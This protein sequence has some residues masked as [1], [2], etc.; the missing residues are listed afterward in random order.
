MSG[1]WRC[2]PAGHATTPTPATEPGSA[3]G[4]TTDHDRLGL[5]GVT[6]GPLRVVSDRRILLDVH[7][8]DGDVDRGDIQAEQILHRA[9]HLLPDLLGYRVDL[10]AELAD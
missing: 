4:R 5:R 6:G 8:V 10:D 1:L 2:Q 7:V 3:F 9:D